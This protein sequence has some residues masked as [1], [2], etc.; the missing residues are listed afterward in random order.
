MT[1]NPINDQPFYLVTIS[2]Q[3][4]VIEGENKTITNAD[5]LTEDADTSSRDLIY[6]IISGPTQGILLK[7]SDE[8]YPQD[9]ITYGNQF[10][11]ADINE[12]RIIY[13]H[14]G[15]PQST[16]FYF[17]VSDG[18]FKP[19][20]EIFNIKILPIQIYPGAETV[21]I[22]VQ[23]GSN[24][25]VLEPK[26]VAIETNVQ[27]N[28]L[29]YN[30]TRL[31]YGG[32]LAN[33]NKQVFR[34]NQ[35]QLEDGVINYVQNDMT[36]SNDSFQ[37]NAYIPD[38]T[39]FSLV[40][41]QVVVQPFIIINPVSI[42][43]G[44]KVRLSST[45]IIDNPTQLKLNRYNPK[46][47]ISRKPKYGKFK[48]IIRSTGDLESVNDKEIFS[49]T[50]KELK[51]GVVYFVARKFFQEFS[52]INDSFE[53]IL[54]TKTAQPSQGVVN[55]EIFSPNKIS[56]DDNPEVIA[57]DTRITVDHLLIL[58]IITGILIFLFMAIMIIRCR[59]INVPK[60]DPDKNMPPALPRPPDFMTLHTTRSMYTPSENDD[61]LP[62]TQSSTP[63][64]V[65]SNVPHCKVIPIGI[66]SSIQDSDPEDMIDMREDALNNANMLRYVYND[67]PEDWSSCGPDVNYS[68]IA[69]P[70]QIPKINPLLRRN[71]YWV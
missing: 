59:S 56:T 52:S 62:V 9:I 29:M 31:P 33:N 66:D 36:R 7:I 27:K 6:D 57:A 70:Q 51:S 43:P 39:S 12:N 40:D 61:S 11:Q 48:K 1:I 3:V 46:I 44:S 68:S 22:N 50:Y 30:I 2:P 10:T 55:I 26:N 32:I 28:R 4:S 58:S 17:K 41:I 49:F 37:V 23:Q 15:N 24:A 18:K 69:Q 54:T 60:D 25:G 67:D 14:T 65:L 53:Y 8:G 63:L 21:P 71:Q 47:T 45:F 16:T 20:Y 38:T 13:T 5:L 42:T 64:P 34:F 35:R 19:A